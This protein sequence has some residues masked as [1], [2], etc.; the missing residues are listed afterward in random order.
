MTTA[1]AIAAAVLAAAGADAVAESNSPIVFAQTDGTTGTITGF[2]GFLPTDNFM[3]AEDTLVDAVEF[4]GIPDFFF[5]DDFARGEPG[6]LDPD[7]LVVRI[8][9]ARNDT[10]TPT[11]IFTEDILLIDLL[12]SV[13]DRGGPSFENY[14]FCPDQPFLVEGGVEHLIQIGGF[15]TGDAGPRGEQD[16]E[17]I[18]FA[19]RGA[20]D[21]D[22]LGPGILFDLTQTTPA[23]QDRG[24]DPPD[25]IVDLVFTLR[26]L[27]PEEMVAKRVPAGSPI[28]WLTLVGAMA[29]AGALAAARRRRD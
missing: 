27:P 12:G 6:F 13:P 16:E 10:Q 26:G 3:L 23:V 14:V 28:A 11:V 7:E 1:H 29:G 20:A 2:P 15:L 22:G 25:G 4:E 5:F 8:T 9:V 21:G 17:E 24:I 19:W 18:R